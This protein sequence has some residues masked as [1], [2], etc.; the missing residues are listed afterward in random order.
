MVKKML[1]A[2][3]REATKGIFDALHKWFDLSCYQFLIKT[4][5]TVVIPFNKILFELYCKSKLIFCIFLN[6]TL[7]KG[8]KTWPEE[9]WSNV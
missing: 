8:E 6:L 5:H 1:L 9:Q 2:L 3:S 4:A 7:K